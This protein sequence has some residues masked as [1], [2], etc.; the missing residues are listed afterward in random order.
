MAKSSDSDNRQTNQLHL[1]LQISSCRKI[2]ATSLD[3]FQVFP[4]SFRLEYKS[5]YSAND[6]NLS[7]GVAVR[8]KGRLSHLTLREVCLAMSARQHW[9]DCSTILRKDI[10]ADWQGL[11]QWWWGVEMV[12][13]LPGFPVH[14]W[15]ST[16]WTSCCTVRA[17]IDTNQK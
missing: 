8:S 10:G 15:G 5:A 12:V 14:R 11:P 7:P 3:D 1:H 13:Y 2:N 17:A 4:A 6:E 16:V 9:G